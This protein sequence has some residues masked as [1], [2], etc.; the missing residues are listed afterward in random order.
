MSTLDSKQ[1]NVNGTI[2]S[3]A[4]LT[5]NPDKYIPLFSSIFRTSTMNQKADESKKEYLKRLFRL[6]F[7]TKHLAVTADTQ[8]TADNA[9]TDENT[10]IQ[11]STVSPLKAQNCVLN[12]LGIDVVSRAKV[13]SKIIFKNSGNDYK[14]TNEYLDKLISTVNNKSKYEHPD[15]KIKFGVEFEFIGL[16]TSNARSNFKDAMC[17]LVGAD[18]YNESLNYHHNSGGKWDLGTDGSLHTTSRG[19]C[20][21]E[22]TTP[23]LSLDSQEDLNTLKRVL[24]LMF[25]HFEAHPNKT[26]GTHVHMSFDVPKVTRTLIKQF[27]QVYK[28][29]ESTLFDKL[30]RADRRGSSNRYCRSVD[31]DYTSERFCKLNFQ[32]AAVNSNN[33]HLEFRQLQGTLDYDKVIA[34]VKLQKMFVE[35]TLNA[36]KNNVDFSSFEGFEFEKTICDDSFNIAD[37]E[38]FLVMSKAVA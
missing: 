6:A 13:T 31:V 19:F 4:Q 1:I 7:Y 17:A 35:Y 34:W 2:F 28:N 25:I 3:F 24:E 32:N 18:N 8:V 16:A 10:S 38:S 15:V 12:T 29:S 20:G 22:L 14:I 26:C 23:I 33:L 5:N 21:Y 11:V 30:V 27:A 36:I 9:N 37:I